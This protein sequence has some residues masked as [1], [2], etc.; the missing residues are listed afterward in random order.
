MLRKLHPINRTFGMVNFALKVYSLVFWSLFA[1]LFSFPVFLI[2]FSRFYLIFFLL[3]DLNQRLCFAFCKQMK[4]NWSFLL[5]NR[6]YLIGGANES[7]LFLAERK[8]IAWYGLWK[9][10]WGKLKFPLSSK[11]NINFLITIQDLLS[12]TFVWIGSRIEEVF[13]FIWE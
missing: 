11:L 9:W 13:T 2:T 12:N 6:F 3:C 8:N 5:L 1:T 4:K 10:L 7:I